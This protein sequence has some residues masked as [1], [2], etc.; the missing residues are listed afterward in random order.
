MEDSKIKEELAENAEQSENDNS[1]DTASEKAEQD[2]S[3]I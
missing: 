2:T 1:E 3:D